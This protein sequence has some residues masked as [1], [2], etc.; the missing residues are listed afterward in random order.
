MRYLKKLAIGVATSLL[1]LS[2]SAQTLVVGDQSYNAQ[3]V[4]EAAGVLN[5]LPYT[6]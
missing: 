4:M 1:C 5:D 3:A 2:A 6:I